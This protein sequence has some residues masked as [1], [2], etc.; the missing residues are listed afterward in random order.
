MYRRSYA[1]CTSWLRTNI[2]HHDVPRI[3]T[4]LI[5]LRLNPLSQTKLPIVISLSRM[6]CF[7]RVCASPCALNVSAALQGAY[8]FSD[9]DST[10]VPKFWNPG[11]KKKRRIQP[12]ST[13]AP[14]IRGHLCYTPGRFSGVSACDRTFSLCPLIARRD[15]KPSRARLA[16]MDLAT[17]FVSETKSRDSISG[18]RFCNG[19]T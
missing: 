7:C 3:S 19:V 6:L 5:L 2:L 8:N 17:G 10:P 13:L 14:R 18:S 11:P 1:T 4:I 16:K 9:T 15:L 12:E